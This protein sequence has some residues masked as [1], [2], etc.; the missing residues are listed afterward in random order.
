MNEKARTKRVCVCGCACIP[1]HTYETASLPSMLLYFKSCGCNMRQPFWHLFKPV[2]ASL[3][4]CIT[5]PSAYSG[6]EEAGRRETF[7]LT[8]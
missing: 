7:S 2:R 4:A 1:V 6:R 3:A 8:L 5:V